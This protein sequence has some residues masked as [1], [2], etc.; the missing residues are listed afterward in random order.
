MEAKLFVNTMIAAYRSSYE[1]PVVE[2]MNEEA[3]YLGYSENGLS[4]QMTE[5]QEYDA[6]TS[7]DGGKNRV[8]T[9]TV[10]DEDMIKIL[11]N[12]IE[13]N[14]LTSKLDCKLYYLDENGDR[15]YIDAIYDSDDDEKIEPDNHTFQSLWNMHTYY[16]YYPKKYLNAWKDKKGEVHEA[17]RQMQFEITSDKV[18]EP[19]YTTLDI[20]VQQLFQ[21]D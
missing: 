16:F 7:A 13:L 4:Y 20:F 11:F 14:A 12:P 1:S 15:I 19:G 5:V 3:E 18:T 8:V 6:D 10:T 9:E 2:I 21:L 17:L